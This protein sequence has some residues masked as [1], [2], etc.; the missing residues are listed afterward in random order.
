M[1]KAELIDKRRQELLA[2]G[3]PP[4]MVNLSLEWALNTAKGMTDYVEGDETTTIKLLTKYLSD[5]EKWITSMT[6]SLSK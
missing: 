3:Y 2:K 6:E 1:S 4:K 5:T